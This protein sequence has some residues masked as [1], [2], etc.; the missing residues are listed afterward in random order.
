MKTASSNL[1]G[2]NPGLDGR[3]WMSDSSQ[4]DPIIWIVGR[5]EEQEE[6]S[7]PI[8][9][10]SAILSF[11]GLKRPETDSIKGEINDNISIDVMLLP[12]FGGAYTPLT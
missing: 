12:L 1:S 9:M 7:C 10:M 2:V 6:D 3:G 8:I 4:S 11:D 5:N